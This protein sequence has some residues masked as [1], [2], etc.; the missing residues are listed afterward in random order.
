MAQLYYQNPKLGYHMMRLVVARLIHD[1]EMQRV[2]QPLQYA[3][4]RCAARDQM[5]RRITSGG[6]DAN[7][8]RHRIA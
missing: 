4:E 1:F 7:L 2:R 3:R 8:L 6:I 5:H